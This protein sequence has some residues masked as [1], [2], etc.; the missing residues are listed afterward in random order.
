MKFFFFPTS[1]FGKIVTYAIY[2]KALNVRLNNLKSMLTYI[3]STRKN[4]SLPIYNS[5]LSGFEIRKLSNLP[6][7]NADPC[8]L[9]NVED[10]LYENSA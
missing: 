6:D 2:I 9:T 7:P 8:N 4:F 5:L 1:H 10:N 3:S